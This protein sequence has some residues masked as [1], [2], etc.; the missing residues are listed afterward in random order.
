MHGVSHGPWTIE[1]SIIKRF[2]QCPS[3]EWVSEWA[4][5]LIVIRYHFMNSLDPPAGLLGYSILHSR[6]VL[7][8]S[9]ISFIRPASAIPLLQYNFWQFVFVLYVLSYCSVT[10]RVVCSEKLLYIKIKSKKKEELK[11]IYFI[12]YTLC[13]KFKSDY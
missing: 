1:R 2:L 11:D 12:K 13:N 5:S 3:R 10:L 6:T 8:D 7:S 9:T 4:A